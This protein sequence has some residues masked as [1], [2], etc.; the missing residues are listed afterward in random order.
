VSAAARTSAAP[1]STAPRRP[2]VRS[3]GY[4]PS[5]SSGHTRARLGRDRI[6]LV[7][8]RFAPLVLVGKR[9]NVNKE[10]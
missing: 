8:L 2:G 4:G 10:R 5:G 7:R 3:P 9:P 1:A 6:D